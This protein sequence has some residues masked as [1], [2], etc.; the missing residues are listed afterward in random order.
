MADK[1]LIVGLGSI[2]RRHLN[3][4]REIFPDAQ[5]AVLTS[6]VASDHSFGDILILH[7][8]S[9]ALEFKPQIS[10][11]CTPAH[12]HLEYATLFL[13]NSIVLVEKPLTSSLE[14]SNSFLHLPE[15]YFERCLI[16]Y[17]LRYMESL[18]YFRQLIHTNKIIGQIYSVNGEVGQHLSSWRP[19]VDAKKSI[20]AQAKMGGGVLLELS[21]EID[22]L[23]WIFGDPVWV[24]ASLRSQSNLV[25]DVEDT[26]NLWIA[27]DDLITKN[28]IVAS[29]NM[30]FL[31]R[32]ATRVCTVIGELGS[33]RWNALK[34]TVEFYG[35]GEREWKI[36]FT[37]N[38]DFTES[39]KREWLVLLEMSR[40]SIPPPVAV[41]EAYAVM[42]II[43][44]F[45]KSN[46]L[47]ARVS[48]KQLEELRYGY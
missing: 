29:I 26:A 24:N 35:V 22:Y 44:G 9:D 15:R 37:K 16:G 3:L 34:G 18:I 12:T 46:D 7:E 20:S 21:H 17:N 42:R 6:K 1:I 5:I 45:R 27:F 32:D 31:R 2:G 13:S 39:Y 47:G 43:E 4:A 23:M 36:L 41:H 30:D 8:I 40:F 10:V 11:I 19:G 25:N 14:D 28:R 48:K 38:D 33:L